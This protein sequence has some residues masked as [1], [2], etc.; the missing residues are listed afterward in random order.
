VLARDELGEVPGLLLVVGPAADLVDAEVGVRAV[1]E[2]DRRGGAAHL[3][4][5]DDVLEIAEAEAA[6][7]LRHGD[8]V[9]P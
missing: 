2:A 4:A 3:L 8:A 6:V 9:Q 1:A 7:L 5:G